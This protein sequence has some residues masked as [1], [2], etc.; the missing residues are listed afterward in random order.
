MRS[1]TYLL[2]YLPEFT[3][4]KVLQASGSVVNPDYFWVQRTLREIKCIVERLE[5]SLIWN[6]YC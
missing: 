6:V 1:L 5:M 2:T 3:E 4:Q